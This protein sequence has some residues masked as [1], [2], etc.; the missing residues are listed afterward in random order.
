MDKNMENYME[1]GGIKGFKELRGYEGH[2]MGLCGRIVV[3]QGV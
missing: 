1:T 3:M 2:I